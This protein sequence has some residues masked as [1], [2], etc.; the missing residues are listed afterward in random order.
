MSYQCP[1]CKLLFLSGYELKR[2]F[3]K[4]HNPEDYQP[5]PSSNSVGE[6]VSD[7]IVLTTGPPVEVGDEKEP[8]EPFSGGGGDFGGAGASGSFGGDDE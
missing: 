1:I 3:T 7:T 5:R 8:D 4:S 2:H 6:A